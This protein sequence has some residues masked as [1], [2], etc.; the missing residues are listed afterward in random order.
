MPV[1]I[2]FLLILCSCSV[3]WCQ[4]FRATLTGRVT[5]P[6]GA[7]VAAARV[8]VRNLET[9]EVTP[10]TTGS[11]GDYSVPFLRPGM[12]QIDVEAKGFKKFRRDG[13]QL[14][15]N[16]V[17]AADIALQVGDLTEQVT[18]TADAELLETSKADRG[19]VIDTE[20]VLEFPLNA[21]NPLM[22]S[23]L[24]AGV[25]NNIGIRVRPF[26]NGAINRWTVNG[27]QISS[28]DWLLD[29]AP[30]N[31][32][33]GANEIAYIP[34]VDSVQEF[35]VQTNTYDAQYGHTGGG[36][37]NIT[38]KSGTNELH[39][40]AYEFF[41]RS[42]LDANS[43]QNNAY[44]A[45]K[46]GHYLDQY[47]VQI[48]G[49]VLLPRLYDGRNRTF[50]M[51]NFENYRE[52]TPTPLNLSVP[53]PEMIK[54]DFS[55]LT[56]AQGR[57]ITIYDPTTGRNVSGV[58]TRNSFSGNQIPQGSLNP[59]A[60]KILGYMPKPNVSTAGQ[61]YAQSN[62][63][64]AGGVINTDVD[65]FHNLVVKIDQNIGSNHRFF[66]RYSTNDREEWRSFNGL[67]KTVAEDGAMPGKRHNDGYVLDWV[68]I[69]NPTT[70]FNARVSF[71]RYVNGGLSNGNKGF[72]LASLGFPSG[73]VSQIPGGP[74]FGRYE[75]SGYVSLGRDAS[76][77][78]TNTW[79]FHPT[80]TR[81]QGA[82]TIK[83]GVDMRWINFEDQTTGWP[84][85]LVTSPQFTQQNYNRADS[86]SG[87]AIASFLL[88]D[89]SSG[90]V[91][92]NAFPSFLSRYFAPYVQDDWK[93]TRR[94]T[95]NLGLRWDAN[96]PPTEKY[97]RLNRGF[98]SSVTSPVGALV[99]YSKFPDL[100]ALKGGMLFAGVGN[101]PRQAADLY[102]STLQPRVGGAYQITSKLV[103]RGGW[104]RY[105]INPDNSYLQRNGFSK[106]TGLVASL[107]GAQTPIPNLLNNPFPAGVQIPSGSSL[108]LNTF[109]ATAFS[110]VNPHFKLPYVNQ[111]SVGFQYELPGRVKI[112][113]SYVGN[114]TR[115]LQTSRSFNELNLATRQAC[116]VAEG[117]N[118]LYCDQLLPNPFYGLAPFLGT[119]Y[120]SSATLTRAN[121]LRP[122]P[123]FGSLTELARNDGAIWYNAL[124]LTFE[125]RRRKGINLISTYTFSKSI[126][127]NGFLDVQRNIVQRG[128][129]ALD[130][131]HRFT[132]GAIYQLPFGKGRR[133][134]STTH[135]FWSRLVSGWESNAMFVWASGIPWT[136][137]ANV[138]YVKEAKIDNIDWSA[139][140]VYG[141]RPCVAR[142]NDNGTITM[143]AFSIAAGCTEYNFLEGPRYGPARLTPISD[144]RLRLQAVPNLDFSL[145]KETR[146]NERLGV[147]FRAEA[148]N[149]M[150]KYQFPLL[151]FNNNPEDA[152]FGSLTPATAASTAASYPRQ[153][154]F[155]VKLIF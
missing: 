112:D 154:Q 95:L 43:F 131:T 116:N 79:A 88:G 20:R 137:P 17:A 138:Y 48:G 103:F 4:D 150:N 91:D 49:P 31:A 23:E 69:A 145:T 39:G 40:T 25:N 37:F 152:N 66:F 114:R 100:A 59:I 7:A 123:Q 99:D 94:L 143:Q 105:Y 108:G 97:N 41:R 98:D 35:K 68:G 132:L 46:S 22:L 44:R 119:S 115:N 45:A 86:L 67:M 118:P 53:E 54:G 61:A 13:I 128:L 38:L 153:I 70:V 60:Q 149:L 84:F 2:R 111:F 10:A 135:P 42:P 122:Y 102:T 9:N 140:K 16:Q 28:A 1:P 36:I 92:F 73:L 89:P 148:F 81:I 30:N 18:V 33:A 134:L 19:T 120:Y 55:R 77:D 90:G 124:Q 82:H 62:L 32:R 80:V 27:S 110:F 107:D 127:Q 106:N 129:A 109:L 141:V 57:L 5:D 78:Y 85:R 93:V 147:Q 104:G 26:D 75:F 130:V 125:T 117:G 14:I 146:V 72:D 113:L 144:G 56:D 101:N 47:G 76:F 65:R 83:A 133:F 15:I 12:Y 8:T 64:L 136:L 142:W 63:F 87:N 74:Y 34:P 21:R 58:W 71:G 96:V 29:G 50:F 155:A 11:Q 121:L 139:P 24:T 51:G 3:V 52:G 151:Q 6:S 126:E